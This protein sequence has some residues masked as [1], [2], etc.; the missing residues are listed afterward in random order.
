MER[1]RVEFGGE[2]L[3]PLLIDADSRRPAEHLTNFEVFQVSFGHFRP[4]LSFVARSKAIGVSYRGIAETIPSPTPHAGIGN[5][6]TRLSRIGR[7]TMA[8]A[9]G[10]VASQVRP[11]PTANA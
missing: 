6:S 10:T 3:D 5:G 1:L 9:G 11:R 8:A 4:L 2:A 7:L